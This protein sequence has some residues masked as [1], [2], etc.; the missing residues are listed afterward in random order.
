MKKILIIED[1]VS[2]ADL[3]KDYLEVDG[4]KV[5]LVHSGS[6]G[7]E[8]GKSNKYDLIIIDV[9][10]PE[11]NGF[12][13]VRELRNILDIPL[14]LV[15]AKDSDI[16]K[17]RGLGLGADDFITKPFSPSELVARV[18]AHIK[19]YEKFAQRSAGDN[20]TEMIDVG[21]LN[22][23]VSAH[24]VI[25]KGSQINLS[26]KEFDILVLLASNPD[27]VFSKEEIYE[28]IWGADFYGDVGTVAV[29]MKKVRE[30]LSD[31]KSKSQLIETLWGVGYRLN[32]HTK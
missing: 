13:I 17:I 28:R 9:M 23:D 31:H 11:K 16:D 25:Y 24:K 1:D 8:M 7:L 19:R 10:L 18:K 29:H 3:E 5:D 26:A 22:I 30:K 21:F 20:R 32:Y 14:F 6:R 15:T 27:R 4:F 2:I 12:E